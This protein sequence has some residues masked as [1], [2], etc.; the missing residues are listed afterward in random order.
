[1]MQRPRNRQG[2]T[3]Q[4]ND[5]ARGRGRGGG[6]GRGRGGFGAN[7]QEHNGNV[8]SINQVISGAFVSIV[9]KVDQPTGR[10]VQGV[11]ADVLTSGNHPRGIKVRLA[12]GRVG[13]V[14]RMVSE[15]AART[16]SEG[17][18]DLGRNSEINGQTQAGGQRASRGYREVREEEEMALPP[19]GYSLGDFLP[20]GHA[21]NKP[22]HAETSTAAL[23]TQSHVCPVCGEFEGD[24][25]A[26]SHHVAQHFD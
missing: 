3:S 17:L 8:P 10:E 1:M 6:R 4:Q 19:S 25:I 22:S 24:E 13:R 20:A 23:D 15:E 5:R 26:V 18:S 2:N 14:Q 7:R 11:V 16:G 9:L 12:D 21:L